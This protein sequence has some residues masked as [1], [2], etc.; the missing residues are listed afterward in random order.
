MHGKLIFQQFVFLVDIIVPMSCHIHCKIHLNLASYDSYFMCKN[1]LIYN[2]LL[3]Y[4]FERNAVPNFVS[5]KITN[6]VVVKGLI[7]FVCYFR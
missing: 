6:T 7:S 4:D 2:I 1:L 3:I 5:N